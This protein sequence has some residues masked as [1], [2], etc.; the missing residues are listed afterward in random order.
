MLRA[1]HME[2]P[3]PSA[4]DR[5]PPRRPRQPATRCLLPSGGGPLARGGTG[6]L[7]E[8]EEAEGTDLLL[9]LKE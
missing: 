7:A 1:S 9:G 5:Q 2:M 3:P 6:A 8:A 4:Q